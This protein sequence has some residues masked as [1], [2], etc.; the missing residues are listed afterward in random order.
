MKNALSRRLA[1][2]G[3][4]ALTTV[5]VAFAGTPAQA[6][7]AS[8]TTSESA[9]FRAESTGTKAVAAPKA[10]KVYVRAAHT[11]ITSS[12]RVQTRVRV[13]A[14]GVRLTGATAQLYIN[15]KPR[16]ARMTLAYQDG[17]LSWGRA[18]GM[19]T[20][21]LRQVRVNYVNPD[22][23]TGT[24]SV[25]SNTFQIRRAINPR[26]EIRIRKS[27]SKL[28]IKGTRWIMSQPNGTWVRV[29]QVIIQRKGATG[30]WKAI[31]KVRPTTKGSFS[32]GYRSKP[33]ASYRAVVLTSGT[34]Q[35]GAT[36]AVK[37]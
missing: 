3:T 21:Q 17:P 16:G 37:L 12:S 4:V 14:S 11:T 6:A 28:S 31:K 30:G 36:R 22:G 20:A 29:S 26:A 10:A 34:V 27:G 15:G 18:A 7:P 1:T 35:G 5:A 2:A 25:S 23:T 32:F 13:V 24:A 33:R 9:T 19:G 8:T